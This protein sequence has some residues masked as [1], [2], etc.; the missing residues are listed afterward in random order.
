[1]PTLNELFSLPFDNEHDL[2]DAIKTHLMTDEIKSI[3]DRHNWSIEDVLNGRF[4]L[5]ASL[6]VEN[7]IFKVWNQKLGRNHFHF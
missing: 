4:T 2:V 6:V 5:G 7:R 3:M 1:M